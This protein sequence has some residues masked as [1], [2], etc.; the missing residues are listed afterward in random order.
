MADYT[1]DAHHNGV[2]RLYVGKITGGKPVL[3]AVL[4]ETP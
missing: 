1:F 3:E 4:D 2:H